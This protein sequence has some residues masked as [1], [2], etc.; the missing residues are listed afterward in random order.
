MRWTAR[1]RLMQALVEGGGQ[2]ALAVSVHDGFDGGKDALKAL[3][4]ERRGEQHRAICQGTQASPD[5][6]FTVG[7]GVSRASRAEQIGFIDE[8][9]RC[10]A[11]AMHI[12]RQAGISI[13]EPFL[14]I[15]DQ[16]CYLTATDAF[17]TPPHT[18]PLEAYLDARLA[19]YASR[20]DQDERMSAPGDEGVDGVSRGA[21]HRAHDEARR[22]QQRIDQG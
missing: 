11:H 17:Q 13:G 4:G 12:A 10:L 8:N 20:N 19:T 2:Q 18:V 1:P 7:Q 5:L 9:Y 6:R 16:Q 21:G 22:A 14:C 3:T 15:Q